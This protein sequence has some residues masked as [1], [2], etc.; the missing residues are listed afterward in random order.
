LAYLTHPA[1]VPVWVKKGGW[2]DEMR[3][4]PELIVVAV[5]L[6][7]TGINCGAGSCHRWVLLFSAQRQTA[8]GAAL[9]RSGL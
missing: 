9:N 8:A 5:V 3:L 1:G 7:S 6:T 4:V 2:F